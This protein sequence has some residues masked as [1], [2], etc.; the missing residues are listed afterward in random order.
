M[1]EDPISRQM[2]HLTARGVQLSARNVRLA[3]WTLV[4][5][6]AALAIAVR[7]DF[8]VG[9]NQGDKPAVERSQPTQDNLDTRVEAPPAMAAPVPT[10][11]EPAPAA[12]ER[13]R[14]AGSGVEDA[15]YRAGAPSTQ[16]RPR[17]RSGADSR[18][19]DLAFTEVPV[20]E[21][22]SSS[23]RADRVNMLSFT[24]RPAQ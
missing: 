2:L 3:T 13:S 11:T 15:P 22:P 14:D 8:F 16:A 5:T 17:Q 4:A 24:E 10:V 7:S 6:I 19:R 9:S 20:S 21:P 1:T 12:V 18:S 23:S